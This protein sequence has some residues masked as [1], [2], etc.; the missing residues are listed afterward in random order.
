[1]DVKTKPRNLAEV[2]LWLTAL[3]DMANTSPAEA[4]S[5]QRDLADPINQISEYIDSVEHS[6]QHCCTRFEIM[7]RQR[8]RTLLRVRGLL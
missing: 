2:N 1:M 3:N 6:P 7:W 8:Y 4:R 5:V